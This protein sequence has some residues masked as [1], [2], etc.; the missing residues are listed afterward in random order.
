MR[1]I[2]R[3]DLVAGVRVLIVGMLQA[4]RGWTHGATV[5]TWTE[6]TKLCMKYTALSDLPCPRSY[7][8]NV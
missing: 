3:S 1:G 6:H 8:L 4:G 2:P 5:Q 7:E